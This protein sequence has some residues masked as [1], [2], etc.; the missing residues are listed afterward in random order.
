MP[1]ANT[2]DAGGMRGIGGVPWPGQSGP[3][4]PVEPSRGRVRTRTLSGRS[5][6]TRAGAVGGGPD[7]PVGDDGDG[8]NRETGD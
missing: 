2:A 8:G 6:Q 7:Q 1:E 4:R 3:E 5:F